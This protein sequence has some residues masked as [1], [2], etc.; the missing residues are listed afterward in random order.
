MTDKMVLTP[1]IM[2]SS[3]LFYFLMVQDQFSSTPI[4][5]V[6]N[7]NKFQFT[8][9]INQNNVTRI[10]DM[11]NFKMTFPNKIGVLKNKVGT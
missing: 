3:L 7:K 6:G 11:F 8:I 9:Q 10:L 4:Q 1:T 2:F 5:E